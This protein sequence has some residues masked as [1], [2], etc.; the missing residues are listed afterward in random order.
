MTVSSTC[1]SPRH[2]SA[3]GCLD[4]A[5]IRMRARGETDLELVNQLLVHATATLL[6]AADATEQEDECLPG[7]MAIFEQLAFVV[8]DIRLRYAT[9]AK[10]RPEHD[11]ALDAL[12]L[13][14]GTVREEMERDYVPWYEKPPYAKGPDPAEPGASVA[15]PTLRSSD[16]TTAR[17]GDA[18]NT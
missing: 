12:A 3:V 16:E 10:W 9:G 15:T 17:Y 11:A 8:D 2:D 18:R 7:M 13:A 6:T 5:W 4:C 1:G 14:M